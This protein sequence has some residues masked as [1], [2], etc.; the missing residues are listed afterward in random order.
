[1]PYGYFKTVNYYAKVKYQCITLCSKTQ[2]NHFTTIW[3]RNTNFGSFTLLTLSKWG[4]SW[5][6]RSV[7]GQIQ[8][9][10]DLGSAVLGWLQEFSGSAASSYVP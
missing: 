1:M 10:D 8:V 2:Q 9:T 6:F 5:S 7:Q 4:G 3:I